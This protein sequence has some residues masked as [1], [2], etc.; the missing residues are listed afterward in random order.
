MAALRN[1]FAGNPPRDA[2]EIGQVVAT[3][4]SSGV[5]ALGGRLVRIALF[6]ALPDVRMHQ[7][8]VLALRQH[9]LAQA[10]P[11]APS[12]SGALTGVLVG[13][14]GPTSSDPVAQARRLKNAFLK[15]ASVGTEPAW[16]SALGRALR[17]ALHTLVQP[18]QAEPFHTLT[19]SA[20]APRVLRQ[21]LD[22][23][24]NAG[25][26][27]DLI[28][29]VCSGPG[30]VGLSREL[31]HAL[32]EAVC[33]TPFIESATRFWAALTPASSSRAERLARHGAYIDDLLTDCT[34]RWDPALLDR[35]LCGLANLHVKDPDGR[36]QLL[37]HALDRAVR[38]ANAGRTELLSRLIDL[39]LLIG[40]RGLCET[41]RNNLSGP[42]EAELEQIWKSAEQASLRTK[43]GGGI[44]VG[45]AR[46][47]FDQAPLCRD[48]RANNGSARAWRGAIGGV[49]MAHDAA[50]HYIEGRAAMATRLIRAVDK[51]AWP[52]SAR[53]RMVAFIRERADH[54]VASSSSSSSSSSASSANLS[55]R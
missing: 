47:L 22:T 42:A 37:R 50:P 26:Y 25:A 38:E 4:A 43:G 1:L 51:T 45:L 14:A 32:L 52:Q 40:Y 9:I 41:L 20:L 28:A 39:W 27:P 54:E 35:A 36:T 33:E 44:Q 55:D 23:C 46:A 13:A 16:H 34:A 31:R 12:V 21:I 6:Q 8:F 19:W 15:L 49:L 5:N 30:G 29:S 18:H 53:E 48:V 7:A 24:D 17:H 3:M 2:A 11:G 10:A